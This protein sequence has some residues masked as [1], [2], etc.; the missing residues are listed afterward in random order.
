MKVHHRNDQNLVAL[1][2][3]NQ[4]VRKPGQQTSSK[5]V[6]HSPPRCRVCNYPGNA[7][8]N[9]SNEIEPKTLNSALVEPSCITNLS[10]C[11]RQE[12]KLYP[13]NSR[14]ISAN[15]SSPSTGTTFPALYSA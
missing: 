11:R 15:A 9:L 5:A 1:N 2:A 4:S 6:I 14:A 13:R 3:I 10:Q 8:S 7:S 12:P